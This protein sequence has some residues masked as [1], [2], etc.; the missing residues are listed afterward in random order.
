MVEEYKTVKSLILENTWV[1]MDLSLKT[2]DF[3][4][5]LFQIGMDFYL[6]LDTF[7]NQGLGLIYIEH[8]T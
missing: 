3:K 8:S 5:V 7:L 1:P 6:C 2:T 4:E